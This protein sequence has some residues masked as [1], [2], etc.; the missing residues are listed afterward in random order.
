MEPDPELV[1][2][3]PAPGRD[4]VAADREER[5]APW[6]NPFIPPGVEHSR[7][8][9]HDHQGP[10]LFRIPAPEATPAVVCPE[11]TEHRADEAEEEREADN[12]VIHPVEPVL[13][14]AGGRG[15]KRSP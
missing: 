5:E 13:H 15:G 8:P 2:A 7:V 10:V 1:G 4:D 14:L 9:E 11:A 12:A 6:T 3:E